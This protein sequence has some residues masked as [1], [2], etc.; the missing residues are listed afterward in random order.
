[1]AEQTVPQLSPAALETFRRYVQ[2]VRERL[3]DGPEHRPSD[4]RVDRAN[5]RL[6][7]D[8][9]YASVTGGVIPPE[10]VT[11][12]AE[13]TVMEFLKQLLLRAT[14]VASARGSQVVTKDDLAVARELIEASE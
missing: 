11:D 7:L 4:P 9:I 2:R 12:A 13:A 1:M 6:G 3:G 8:R 5:I 10:P 14:E